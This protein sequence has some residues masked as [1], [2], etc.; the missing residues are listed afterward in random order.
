MAEVN[1]RTLFLEI[2]SNDFHP[3]LKRLGF[4]GKGQK[5][6]RIKEEV[7][8]FLEIE[9]SK[10]D[11]VCYV[12]MGI[13]PL[14]F[15]DTPWEDKKISDAKKITFAD[16]PIHFRLKSK[17]GSDSW[18]YGKGDDSQAK[19]SVKRLVQAYSENGEPI[20]QRADSLSKLSNCYFET[21]INAYSK[22]ED[23]GIF[24]TN[25]PPLMA[26]VHFHLGNLDLAV[27]FLRG[28]IE[29]FQKEPNAWRFK[30]SIDKLQSAI[31]EIEK[32]RQ[33]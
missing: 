24:N 1:P 2:L 31:S 33:M 14:M 29:Y 16:C 26:Q 15:L 5:Y 7:V 4:E 23:F 28:G 11:G 32:I 9:G 18:S 10:W 20:F 6:K 13:F 8:E 12:E 27:K 17:S 22:I 19:E 3:I 30:E 21:A 25:I